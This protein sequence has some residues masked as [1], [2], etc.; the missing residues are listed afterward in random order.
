MSAILFAGLAGLQ[1]A[2]GYFAAQNI[3]ETARLN[4]D[5]ADLNAE[6]A[7]LDA[8]DA[9]IEGFTQQARYQG[10]VDK[11]LGEQ[12]EILAAADV[13]ITFG[14]AGE[15][16]KETRIIAEI[17][18]MEIEKQANERSLGFK[19]EARDFRVSGFLN[20]LQDDVRASN[21]KFQ[22]IVGAAGTGLSGYRR[23]R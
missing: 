2:G 12:T 13:D 11:T 15:L 19:A 17:N 10:I 6:F 4:Q 8:Y 20:R 3:K 9:E 7:E 14:T 1:L 23:T 21:V 16:Q 18:K 22:A 5:I